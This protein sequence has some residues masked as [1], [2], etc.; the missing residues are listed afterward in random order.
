MVY[1]KYKRKVGGE[2][3]WLPS[4]NLNFFGKKDCGKD[5]QTA[6]DKA[7]KDFDICNKKNTTPEQTTIP[8]PATQ[9]EQSNVPAQPNLQPPQPNL[10]PAQHIGGKRRRNKTKGGKK[11]CNKKSKKN[12]KNKMLV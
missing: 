1:K 8:A 11:K 5:K 6:M 10:Q 2:G 9:P 4:F 3:S 7:N 12:R